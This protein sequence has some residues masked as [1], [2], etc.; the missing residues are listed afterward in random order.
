MYG[1]LALL[2]LIT[3]LQQRATGRA[4]PDTGFPNHE[5]PIMRLPI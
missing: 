1:A 2:A 3:S 5:D 4:H